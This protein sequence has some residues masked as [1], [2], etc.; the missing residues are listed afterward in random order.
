MEKVPNLRTGNASADETRQKKEVEAVD[1]NQVA[2]LIQL[3]HFLAKHLVHRGVHKPQVLL[4]L[5][6]DV[7]QI[8]R[9][10]DIGNVVH[11]RPQLLLAVHIVKLK[12]HVLGDVHSV[13]VELGQRE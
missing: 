5:G 6:R 13:A 1:P 10:V 11:D 7:V 9:A 8:Q 12:V 4:G 2:R 3:E